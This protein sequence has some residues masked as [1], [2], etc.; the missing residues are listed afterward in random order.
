M[1][2]SWEE[3]QSGVFLQER[4]FSGR[5]TEHSGAKHP[6]EEEVRRRCLWLLRLGAPQ[7]RV[8]SLERGQEP[9]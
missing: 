7:P 6:S 1:K 8:S 5:R 4:P 2:A 9:V 3:E